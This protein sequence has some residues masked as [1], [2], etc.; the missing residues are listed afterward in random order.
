MK[1]LQQS[2]LAPTRAQLGPEQERRKSMRPVLRLLTIVVFAMLMSVTS[3]TFSMPV[4]TEAA[5]GYSNALPTRDV[6]SSKTILQR[7]L[8][9][10]T[11]EQWCER[12]SASENCAS[13]RSDY[14]GGT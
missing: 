10:V 9:R 5:R 8:V 14:S 2:G 13:D 6:A 3:H 4:E 1:S 12:D 11:Q 7:W